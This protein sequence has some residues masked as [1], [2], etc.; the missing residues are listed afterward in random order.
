M[1]RLFRSLQA[2]HDSPLSNILIEILKTFTLDKLQS[3]AANR[4]QRHWKQI[5]NV[6]VFVEFVEVVDLKNNIDQN[7]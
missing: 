1:V 3:Q 6:I 4:G 5:P 7:T 2:L